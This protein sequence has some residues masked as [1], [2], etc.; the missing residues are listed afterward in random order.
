MMKNRE[1]KLGTTQT[2]IRNSEILCGWSSPEVI[3]QGALIS[4]GMEGYQMNVWLPETTNWTQVRTRTMMGAVQWLLRT[5]GCRE[6]CCLAGVE[7]WRGDM[8]TIRDSLEIPRRERKE[9]P[10]F[11]LKGNESCWY[12]KFLSVSFKDPFCIMTVWTEIS[13]MELCWIEAFMVL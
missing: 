5:R 13:E 2:Y 12:N 6:A 10:N 3:L 4:L 9:Y 8:G 1:V 11:S 7:T